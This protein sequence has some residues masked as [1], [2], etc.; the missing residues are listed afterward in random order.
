MS[1]LTK[2]NRIIT[3]RNGIRSR[4]NTLGV[5]TTSAKL[6]TCK[7]AL[8]NISD[9]TRNTTPSNPIKGS[10]YSG[11]TN[12]IFA[13]VG[14]G[15]CSSNT[16]IEV[17]IKNLMPE[18]IKSGINIGGVAGTFKPEH[19]GILKFN[20]YNASSVSSVNIYDKRG[21]IYT[22]PSGCNAVDEV[23]FSGNMIIVN[24]VN[25]R[26]G[27][28]TGVVSLGSSDRY[29]MLFRIESDNPNIAVTD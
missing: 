16:L 9:N 26:R 12:K 22:G 10:F 3:L 19:S 23:A 14:E 25:I 15:Y 27:S 6:E 28:G 5:V 17:S 24:S 8:D 29:S 13:K 7:T 4:L 11:T 1:I 18:N 2:I 20:I 21:L